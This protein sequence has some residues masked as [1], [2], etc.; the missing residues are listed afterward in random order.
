M[1]AFLPVSREEVEV[2]SRNAEG[3]RKPRRPQSHQGSSQICEGK[4]ALHFGRIDKSRTC[5]GWIH[6]PGANLLERAVD[7]KHIK[8]VA[9]GS[10]G[11]TALLQLTKVRDRSNPQVRLG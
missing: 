5:F 9:R 3:A 1:S 6:R 8:D 7:S 10:Q 11:I 4:L 2:I